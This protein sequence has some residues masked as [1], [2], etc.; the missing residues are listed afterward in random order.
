MPRRMLH[1]RHVFAPGVQQATGLFSEHTDSTARSGPD[2]F[3]QARPAGTGQLRQ[4]SL[5]ETIRGEVP[6]PLASDMQA[7]AGR[8]GASDHAVATSESVPSRDSTEQGD[9]A[10]IQVSNVETD[11]V[12]DSV[13]T[14]RG[15]PSASASALA[16]NDRMEFTTVAGFVAKDGREP[17]AEPA[18]LSVDG[19]LPPALQVENATGLIPLSPEAHTAEKPADKNLMPVAAV[20]AGDR[21]TQSQTTRAYRITTGVADNNGQQPDKPPY[22]E[23]TPQASNKISPKTIPEHPEIDPVVQHQQSL[24][25]ALA[26]KAAITQ[27]ELKSGMANAFSRAVSQQSARHTMPAQALIHKPVT[28]SAMEHFSS[29]ATFRSAM[30]GRNSLLA[31]QKKQQPEVVIGQIDVIVEAPVSAPR[32]STVTKPTVD[33]SSKYYLRGL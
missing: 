24:E 7:T 5:S 33:I 10:D 12:G 15:R 23:L 18:W 17:E 13:F 11:H 31:E 6:S 9:Q 32:G 26:D 20:T 27:S 21:I 8:S 1:Q 25:S 19:V 29:D 22:R 2:Q 3:E 30:S 16:V 14:V 4:N 28:G